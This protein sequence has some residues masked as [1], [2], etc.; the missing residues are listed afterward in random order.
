M[1][2][3]PAVSKR[4]IHIGGV[5][6]GSLDDVDRFVAVATLYT[7]VEVERLNAVSKLCVKYKIDE[8]GGAE[9]TV[10][11]VLLCCMHGCTTVC[12]SDTPGTFAKFA[13]TFCV[14]CIVIT[15]A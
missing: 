13:S 3:L 8:G 5:A 11:H 14:R 4:T 12:A 2:C 7:T 6:T 9:E 15:V 10:P 1:P